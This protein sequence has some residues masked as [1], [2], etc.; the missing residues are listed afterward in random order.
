M[1][2]SGI[3]IVLPQAL[4]P[5]GRFI[6]GITS[7]PRMEY[8]RRRLSPQFAFFDWEYSSGRTTSLGEKCHSIRTFLLYQEGH[9]RHKHDDFME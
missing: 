7:V 6:S 8:A 2:A 1:T 5:E 9:L 4:E 3:A